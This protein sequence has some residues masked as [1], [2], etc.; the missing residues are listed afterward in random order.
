MLHRRTYHG[1]SCHSHMTTCYEYM[2]GT[3]TKHMQCKK[4]TGQ[5]TGWSKQMLGHYAARQA[6]VCSDAASAQA[7]NSLT[8]P[9]KYLPCTVQ[10]RSVKESLS[11]TVQLY[12]VNGELYKHTLLTGLAFDTWQAAQECK[13][14]YDKSQY[15][16]GSCGEAASGGMRS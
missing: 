9:A 7:D 15:H 16:W 5:H 6:R 13:S 14:E 8:L 12:I 10:M 11:R 1:H 4:T 3:S 2:Y